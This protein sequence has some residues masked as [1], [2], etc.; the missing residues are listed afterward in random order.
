MVQV[1][2]LQR[3]EP[4]PSRPSN[5]RINLQAQNNASDIV[6][7]T[8]AVSSVV[9]A[10]ANLYQQVEDQQIANV[11]AEAEKKFSDW[12]REKLNSLKSIQGDPTEAYVNYDKE[13]KE[14]RDSILASYG[15]LSD[16]AKRHVESKFS[17]VYDRESYASLKQRGAQQEA[18]D[19]NLYESTVKLKANN[20][21]TSASYIQAGKPQSYTM[22]NEGIAD[23]AT[24]IAERALKQGNAKIVD[25]DSK[26]FSH[27]YR[28]ADGNVVT[29]KMDNIA[30]V[31]LAK[32]LSNSIT[33]GIKSLVNAGYGEAAKETYEKYKSYIDPKQ[34][35]SLT[36]KFTKES[37][38]NEARRIYGEV[39]G[40]S[41]EAQEK[42]I[43][44]ISDPDVK[45]EL[46]K[47]KES[48]ESRMENQRKRR[49]KKSY[50]TLSK[51]VLSRMNSENPISGLAELE[52]EQLYG[53]TWEYL[54]SKSREAITEMVKAPKNSNNKAVL[55]VQELFLEGS[56]E[57]IESMSPEEF[58][59]QLRGLSS[60]D[61]R[62]YTNMY[63]TRKKS[64]TGSTQ[65]AVFSRAN[66]MLQ[67]K[68]LLTGVIKR[69][70]RGFFKPKDEKK[71]IK[72]RG[73]L[74]DFLGDDV[75]N[76]NDKEIQNKINEF[77]ANQVKEDVGWFS[78]LF[79]GGSDS[80]VKTD[81]VQTNQAAPARKYDTINDVPRMEIIKFKKAYKDKFNEGVLKTDPKFLRFI[82]GEI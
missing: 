67:D 23:I 41:P 54:D 24:T 49:E 33:G 19:H 29:V 28:D 74:I 7:R 82:N 62:K 79:G 2:R 1:P 59:R 53:E 39:Q 78:S 17:K 63:E 47:Y 6:S 42:V 4:S 75:G 70:D 55:R 80:V 13:A 48:I 3:V 46:L 77:T 11:S 12:N 60:S 51:Y 37:N 52:S 64:P 38:K 76:L 32:E 31:R 65:R 40:K 25:N 73:E 44:N 14:M 15:D 35:V 57:T 81:T 10:G 5:G 61:R 27:R 22:F 26:D 66:K 36:N 69:N 72:L 30:K 45:L 8:S 20:L 58:Q 56:E 43:N 71:L 9:G 21:A 34:K 50:E 68:L 18:Y 16:R